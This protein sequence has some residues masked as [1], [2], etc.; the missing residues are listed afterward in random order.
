V[1]GGVQAIVFAPD[2]RPVCERLE[3]NEERV[4]TAEV[5]LP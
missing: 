5:D 3:K 1:S 4:L 2:G